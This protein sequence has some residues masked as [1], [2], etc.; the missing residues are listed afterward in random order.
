MGKSQLGSH[1][2]DWNIAQGKQPGGQ[3]H[4]RM[5][6]ILE[7]AINSSASQQPD[8]YQGGVTSIPPNGYEEFAAELILA[9]RASNSSEQ[10]G[11]AIALG[12]QSDPS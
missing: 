8:R 1:D 6:F 3:R 9:A 11:V 4:G 5:L 2:L 12:K 7:P 10:R